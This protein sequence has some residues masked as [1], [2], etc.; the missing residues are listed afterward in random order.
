VWRYYGVGWPEKEWSQAEHGAPAARDEIFRY[1]DKFVE[2][3]K[4][5]GVTAHA[6]ALFGGP[7]SRIIEESGAVEGALIVMSTRGAS[8]FARWA[9]GSIADKVVR[10][11]GHP[12]LVVPPYT[13]RP[14]W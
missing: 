5:H 6:R 10:S 14:E 7:A 1:L 8:G 13:A 3:A 11:S 4:S 12:V 9:L 2:T